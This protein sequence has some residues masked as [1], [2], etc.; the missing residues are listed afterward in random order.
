MPTSCGSPACGSGAD[1][2]SVTLVTGSA[3][4]GKTTL[5]ATWAR[6]LDARGDGVGWVTLS[7]DDND[8]ASLTAALLDAIREALESVEPASASS[9][10][11]QAAAASEMRRRGS[12]PDVRPRLSA[13]FASLVAAEIVAV[14]ADLWLLIDDVHLVRDPQTLGTLE[15]L[16]NRAPPNLHV[17]L[18]ARAD[19]AVHLSKL[20]LQERLREVRDRDLRLSRDET[21]AV[22]ALHGIHL[23][24]GQVARLHDLTEG[25]AAGVGLAALSLAS[26]RDPESFLAAFAHDDGA[27]AAYLVDEVLESIDDDR[28]EF[29]LDTCVPDDLPEALAVRLSGRDDAGQVLAQLTAAN[30]LLTLT[31]DSHPATYRYHALLRSY[32]RARLRA[33][34]A[35]RSDAKHAETAVWFAEQGRAADALEHAAASADH[36]LF[37][38]VLH[39]YAV[40][41]LL[42]GHPAR[43]EGA[44]ALVPQA[45]VTDPALLAVAAIAS[46]QSGNLAAARAHLAA[47]TTA[48]A[49]VETSPTS[50]APPTR[51]ESVAALQTTPERASIPYVPLPADRLIRVATWGE[52]QFQSPSG[53]GATPEPADLAQPSNAGVPNLV[54]LDLLEQLRQA[55]ALVISGQPG[56]GRRLFERALHQARRSGRSFAV[57]SC[58]TG[59]TVASAA[60]GERAQMRRWA[61]EAIS[62]AHRSGL[63]SSTDLLLPHTLAAEGALEHYDIERAERQVSAALSIIGPTTDRHPNGSVGTSVQRDVV[64]TV[65]R[66]L[67]ATTTCIEFTRADADPT[68]QRKIVTSRLE[69]VRRL[70][71]AAGAINV[72]TY[73]LITLH[74]MALVT[75]QLSVAE[76]VEALSAAIP[77]LEG[78]LRVMR[79]LRSLRLGHDQEARSHVAPVVRRELRC[80]MGQSEVT[81]QLIEVTVARRNQ[82]ATVAHEALLCAL[83]LTASQDGLRMMLGVSADVMTALRES[84]GRFGRHESVVDRLIEIGDAQDDSTGFGRTRPVAGFGAAPL[85]SPR[86]LSL[87]R[88]LPSLL[89]VAEI[90]RARSVS[91]NTIKTQLRSL[92][93]KLEV[94]TRRDAVAAG[95]HEGLI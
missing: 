39:R 71:P 74:R 85:L 59:L 3:G 15:T 1:H 25:W 72:T 41:Q 31:P 51:S 84:R 83:D 62:H 61:D 50:P 47:A 35:Q 95:R 60:A 22:A 66:T 73:E 28:R 76:A 82:Q 63:G 81:A 20:R 79:G 34:S 38:A 53:A 57:L 18:G 16:L 52:A 32:L 93:E 17:V 80:V 65:M 10:Q 30:S 23:D 21:A 70:P 92:F 33:E 64:S 4:A 13:G 5:M 2:G 87:L 56:E 45:V 24:E 36:G 55:L 48:F 69:E 44:I 7:R 46:L 12:G 40:G 67:R 29:M 9:W 89:T 8:P 14:G 11:P 27:V 26:G 75:A 6:A 88:E 58:L 43:I 86:E 19:P 49:L 77:P 68:R 42:D 91:P 37:R 78:D 94:S 90:A 54:D